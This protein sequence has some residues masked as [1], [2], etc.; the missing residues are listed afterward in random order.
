MEN[1]AENQRDYAR[2]SVC[3]QSDTKLSVNAPISNPNSVWWVTFRFWECNFWLCSNHFFGLCAIYLLTDI[4]CFWAMS[5]EQP[6][7]ALESTHQIRDP[8]LISGF[9]L[10]FACIRVNT[11]TMRALLGSLVGCFFSADVAVTAVVTTQRKNWRNGKCT[12]KI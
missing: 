2:F 8:K 4:H 6:N 3:C 1:T 9:R 7:P 12:I 11:M 5:A 10:L